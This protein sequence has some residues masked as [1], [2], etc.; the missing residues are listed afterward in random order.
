VGIVHC[1]AIIPI[2]H[3]VGTPFPNSLYNAFVGFQGCD[4]SIGCGHIRITLA[5]VSSA[6]TPCAS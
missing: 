4:N 2:G 3:N 6:R 5:S 1:F